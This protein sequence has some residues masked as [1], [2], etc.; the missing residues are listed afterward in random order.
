MLVTIYLHFGQKHLPNESCLNVMGNTTNNAFII[1]QLR[2][3]TG[4]LGCICLELVSQNFQNE[5]CDLQ[6]EIISLH[7]HFDTFN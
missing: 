3:L 6:N 5:N 7:V 2:L 1:L 4:L